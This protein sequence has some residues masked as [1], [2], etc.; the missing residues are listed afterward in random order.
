MNLI[1]K[2]KKNKSLINCIIL[3]SIF[4]IVNTIEGYIYGKFGLT[5]NVYILEI[6]SF[7]IAV[8]LL[9]K[10]ICIHEEGKCTTIK[11]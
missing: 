5:T 1:R 6:L 9:N 2:Y 7:L 11:K 4:S 3:L 8:F 10:M